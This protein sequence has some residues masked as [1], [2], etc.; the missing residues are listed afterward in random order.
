V[1]T[2]ICSANRPLQESIQDHG[3]AFVHGAAMRELL[4][5]CGL[6]ADWPAFADSW[7]ALELDTYMA[8][9]GRYRRRR[10]A[11]YA[12]TAGRA[13]ERQAHQPHYQTLDYNPLHGGIARWFAPVCPEVDEG[14]SLNTILAFCRTLFGTLDPTIRAWRI[15]VHQFRIEA[16]SGELG[17][18]TPEGL[19]RDGVDFVLVLL[20]SR[21]NIASG[22]TTI[23][24]LEGR[25]LGHFTLTDPLDAALV[26]D[27]RVA[28]GVT[29]VEALDPT[30]PACRDVLVV[31]FA[32]ADHAGAA[33]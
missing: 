6:L 22:V 28:H 32:N 21:R 29:P 33:S 24:A 8:D 1:G 23:H 18:P 17:R 4:K 11:V 26:D 12:A 5:P 14:A 7:N 25:R 20:V 13:I 19:H 31:T 9:G 10:H 16:R 2:V 30:Q 27:R 3:Y 15:E